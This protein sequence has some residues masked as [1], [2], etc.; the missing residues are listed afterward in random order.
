MLI[1]SAAV[2]T[3]GNIGPGF[4]SLAPFGS[5][6][7]GRR[8][9][10]PGPDDDDVRLTRA[11]RIISKSYRSRGVTTGCNCLESRCREMACTGRLLSNARVD[12]TY[13]RQYQSR[14]STR[15]SYPSSAP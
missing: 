1:V 9:D 5:Y 13:N 4:G 11:F 2:A 7:G 3:L 8:P 14:R 6:L 12:F 10:V 15:S